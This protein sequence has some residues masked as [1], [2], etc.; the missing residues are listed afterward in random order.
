MFLTAQATPGPERETLQWRR[1]AMR[2]MARRSLGFSRFLFRLLH[3]LRS[4]L[5][6]I[7][8][9]CRNGQECDEPPEPPLQLVR[10]DTFRSEWHICWRLWGE[11]D[12]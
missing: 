11:I 4:R 12:F 9:Q 3:G 2:S 10:G 7:I 6:L 8:D 5:S 1:M